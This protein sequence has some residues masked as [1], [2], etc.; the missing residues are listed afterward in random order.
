MY[1]VLVQFGQFKIFTYGFFVALGFLIGIYLLK[2]E[3]VRLGENSEAVLDLAFYSVVA[4]IIGAR[5]FYIATVPEVFKEDPIEVFR[6]WNGGLVFYGG[7]ICVILVAVFYTRLN[8]L[9]FWRVWDM[10]APSIAIGHGIGRLGC[11]FAGCCYGRECHLPWAI[12]FNHPETLAPMGASL[13]PTQIYASISNFF[14]F[15]FLMYY[16]KYVK[17]DGQLFC[18]YLILYA[19]LRMVIEYFRGDFRGDFGFG[20]FSV[21]Q[22]IAFL[23]IGF[24]IFLLVILKRRSIVK[25]EENG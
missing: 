22:S 11:L 2:R 1:P 17:F 19:L 25:S 15:L 9:P 16:R 3:A 14:L 12:T 18:V 20:F 21:S 4:A 13:H 10:A 23:M 5:I 7:L 24:S 8:Q 6:L